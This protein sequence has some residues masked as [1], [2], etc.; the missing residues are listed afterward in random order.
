MARTAGGADVCGFARAYVGSRAARASPQPAEDHGAW[1]EDG[2]SN[3]RPEDTGQ[4]AE[5]GR[6]TEEE[7]GGMQ[8]ISSSCAGASAS[9][10]IR[11]AKARREGYYRARG[12]VVR[13]TVFRKVSCRD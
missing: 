6:H 4:S 8:V 10:L 11:T 3:I 13:S 2:Q 5:L 7:S 1:S 9:R 12:R